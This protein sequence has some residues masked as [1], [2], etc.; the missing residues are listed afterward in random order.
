M[1][2]EKKTKKTEDKGC[3]TCGDDRG[4]MLTEEKDSEPRCAGCGKPLTQHK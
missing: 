2:D 4:V 3:S 1:A